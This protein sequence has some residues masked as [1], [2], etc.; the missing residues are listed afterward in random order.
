MHFP[1]GFLWGAATSAYQIEG[2]RDA[3]GKGLSVWDT[4]CLRPGAIRNDDTG[5]LACDH[6]RRWRDDV[7]LI[8]E[9]GL[10]AY[11][12]SLSWPRILPTGVGAV[13]PA[14]L[15]FYERL[16][17]ALL[18]E[19]IVPC[20]TLYHWDQPQALYERGGWLHPDSPAWFAEYA[21]VVA[22]RLSDRVEWWLTL[23]EPEIFIGLGYGAGVHA[24]GEQLVFSQL[25]RVVHHAL[26]GHGLAVQALRARAR[27][28]V[29][30]GMANA[31]SQCVPA[32]E[33]SED[34]E[35]ARKAMFG[36][37]NAWNWGPAWLLD[38]LHLGRYPDDQQ[39]L[40]ERHTPPFPEEEVKTIAQ[41]LDFFGLNLYFAKVVR[42]GSEGRAEEVRPAM[43]APRT[44]LDWPV[45]PQALYWVPRFLWERYRKP[46]L[47]TE[48]GL[49]C[50][51]WVSLDGRV[52][53]PQRVDFMARY[54]REL[55]RAMAE[56]VEVQGYFHWSLFDN[57][58]WAE[59]YRE[60][61]GLVYVDYATQARVPKESAGFYK[62][63]IETNG[64]AL[65]EAG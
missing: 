37:V 1:D 5:D 53:D 3:D 39:R 30:I 28:T 4:F 22:D 27:R 33:S 26:L 10:R 36:P 35:A 11:R 7:R 52:H 34:V 47:I 14:G 42:A 6:Y 62:R 63:V 38:P 49:S 18:A 55:G 40:F 54:L 9:L 16:V 59:G 25:L 44:A 12:F 60:R 19:G 45:V 23:N 58:E 57:F 13:N 43:G 32:T 50:R 17:D 24:P 64:R 65:G 61:F 8:R 20:L 48:N 51:D 31:V 29:R 56:G 2:A 41:P 15:D 46:L 21:A